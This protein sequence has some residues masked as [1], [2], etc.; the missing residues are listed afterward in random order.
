ME[1]P[2]RGGEKRTAGWA[3]H[4]EARGSDGAVAPPRCDHR[5][6]LPR[7]GVREWCH[8]SGAAV[9]PGL[10]AA[11]RPRRAARAVQG[12]V[13]SGWQVLPGP[14][15]VPPIPAQRVDRFDDHCTR[16]CL[17]HN[18][19]RQRYSRSNTNG[20][21]GPACVYAIITLGESPGRVSHRTFGGRWGCR[22]APESH[23]AAA[24]HAA[25]APTPPAG[26]GARLQAFVAPV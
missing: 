6:V 13:V 14:P 4:H 2:S 24:C 15:S 22:H 3:S 5:M 20:Y 11:E 17:L 8:P 16:N 23:G 26:R 10:H 1:R 9:A 7:C 12:D 25:R 21:R 19:L 18:K